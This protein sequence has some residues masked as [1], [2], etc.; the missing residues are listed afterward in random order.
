MTVSVPVVVAVL[1]DSEGIAVFTRLLAALIQLA[2]S[3]TPVNSEPE[4]T[5]SQVPI[6][7]E[8]Y[9]AHDIYRRGSYPGLAFGGVRQGFAITEA[10]AAERGG[11]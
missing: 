5:P 7:I 11:Q 10:G 9:C 3:S 4:A 1:A 6:G 8:F 2:A